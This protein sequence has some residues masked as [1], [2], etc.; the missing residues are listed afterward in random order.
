MNMSISSLIPLLGWFAV[1]LWLAHD[2]LKYR[3]EH[4]VRT[5]MDAAERFHVEYRLMKIHKTSYRRAKA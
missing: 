4:M 1:I 3:E 2:I 5:V